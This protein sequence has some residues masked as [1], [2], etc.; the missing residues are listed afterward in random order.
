MA[1]RLGVNALTRSCRIDEGEWSQA[2]LVDVNMP[3]RPLNKSPS[4]LSVT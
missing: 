3:C 4:E 1:K 2:M